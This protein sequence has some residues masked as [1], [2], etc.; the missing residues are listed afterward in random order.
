MKPMN[1]FCQQNAITEC[2]SRGALRVKGEIQGSH[3]DENDDGF[4]L[5]CWT[6]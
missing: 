6:L 1:A 2:L 4:L 3:G 5:V